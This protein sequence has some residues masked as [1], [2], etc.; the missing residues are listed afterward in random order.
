MRMDE[1]KVARGSTVGERLK[2]ART[3]K[4]MSLEDIAAQT[5]I[6]LRHL[7]SVEESAWDRLPAPTYTIGFAKAYAGAVGIDRAE[8]SEQLREELGGY[9]YTVTS[10]DTFEPADPARSMPKWLVIGAIIAVLLVVLAMTWL[11]K[12][13]LQDSAEPAV[14][15]E[16]PPAAA[17]QPPPLTAPTPQGPVVLKAKE[18]VW[19]Q[20][21]EKGGQTYYSGT[22]NA[23][24]DY[25]VPSTATAPLLKTGKPEGLTITVGSAVA[26]DVGPPAKMVSDVSLL[27]PDLMKGGATA[28]TEPVPASTTPAA[29]SKPARSAP[30][31]RRATTSAPAPAPATTTT[32]P[33]PANTTGE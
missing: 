11:N 10:V 17:N 33:V 21:Y 8:V 5:R 22:L 1:E 4:K 12:R 26:P 9:R 27:G 16:A 20:V 15:A 19:L 3:K 31:R 29:A 24:E 25:T 13:A 23:G 2:A 30:P 18:P 6:P 28:S 32:E 7:Q 14:N